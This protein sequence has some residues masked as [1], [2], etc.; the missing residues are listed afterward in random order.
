MSSGFGQGSAMFED[1][2][3][4]G[5]ELARYLVLDG[6]RLV[7]WMDDVDNKMYFQC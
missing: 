5:S 2:G 1:S 7:E 3:I 4:L 6:C